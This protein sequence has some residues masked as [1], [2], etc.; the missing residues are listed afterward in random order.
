MG[1]AGRSLPAEQVLPA[2][3]EMARDI[4]I[5][6]APLSVAITKR[7]LWESPNL[8]AAQV[9]HRETELHHHLMGRVDAIEGV[10]AWLERRPPE[11]K[12]SVNDD[13]PS[14]PR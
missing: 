3:L 4:A 8:T 12:L 1:L 10:R 14:W 6:T 9:G 5:N 7:L 13:W 2:A 11:W